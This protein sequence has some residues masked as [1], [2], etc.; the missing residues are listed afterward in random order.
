[1]KEESELEA[2]LGLGEGFGIRRTAVDMKFS[3]AWCLKLL[4]HEIFCSV[5][6]VELRFSV[7]GVFCRYVLD[8]TELHT[9]LKEGQK[10]NF[11]HRRCKRNTKPK[12]SLSVGLWIVLL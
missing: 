9:H 11:A 7:W 5:D 12:G 6:N 1:M 2:I 4:S 10:Y 3:A 8:H